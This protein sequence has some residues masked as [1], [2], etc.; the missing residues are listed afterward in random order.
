MNVS[1]IR[2]QTVCACLQPQPAGNYVAWKLTLL[3]LHST[4]ESRSPPKELHVHFEFN[5][6]HLQYWQAIE[7]AW[8]HGQRPARSLLQH[9]SLQVAKSTANSNLSYINHDAQLANSVRI[10]LRDK[11]SH[12]RRTFS[13]LSLQLFKR[14]SFSLSSRRHR[15]TRPSAII[16]I[17]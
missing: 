16:I 17:D 9:A 10:S 1:L 2:E 7:H 5:S 6:V 15:Q 3:I 13:S 8:A 4:R 11:Q 12:L 14:Y